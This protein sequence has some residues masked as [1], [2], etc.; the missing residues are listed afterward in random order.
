MNLLEKFAAVEI[1]ADNRIA[2]A[3]RAYCEKNQAAY[4]AAIDCFKELSFFWS[5]VVNQQT[6]LL[7]D[8]KQPLFHNYLSSED[9]PAISP[10]S[11]E[12]HIE[13]LHASFIESITKYFNVTYHVTVCAGEI[14][15]ALVPKK[16]GKWARGKEEDQEFRARMQSLVIRY[17]DVVEQVILRLNGRG[18][19]GQAFHELYCKCHEA[20]WDSCQ[21]QPYFE[22]KKDTIQFKTYFCHYDDFLNWSL[23]DR[24]KDVLLGAAH[25]ETGRYDSFPAELANV[26]GR[27]R[28]SNDITEFPGCEKLRRLKMFKSGRV[29][30]KFATESCADEFVSQYL[31]TAF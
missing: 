10:E 2:E 1:K 7:G 14:I 15:A 22:R 4:E 30:L 17:Q 16:P 28:F 3:D 18:F 25:F 24:M 31:G 20:A 26:I 11:I 21:H 29:D 8:G 5:D 12:R 13:S 27:R 9:G 23:R 6:E 19:D